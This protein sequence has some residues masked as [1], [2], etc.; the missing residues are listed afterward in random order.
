MAVPISWS[1][2]H[3][4]ATIK[5]DDGEIILVTY[6]GVINGSKEVRDRFS[7]GE[8]P[9]SKD[10]ESFITAPQF[11]TGSKKYDWLNHTQAVG[12]MVSIQRG[13]RSNTLG[14]SFADDIRGGMDHAFSLDHLTDNRYRCHH[15][16][17]GPAKTGRSEHQTANRT[18]HCR[19]PRSLDQTRRCRDC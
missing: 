17:T 1:C 15:L 4:R 8:A 18:G 7:N 5:T 12:K 16:S 14:L 13:S 11:T 2:Q 6:G 9:T 19:V 10:Y 3:A